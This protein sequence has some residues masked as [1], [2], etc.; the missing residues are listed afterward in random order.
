MVEL[1]LSHIIVF[2]IEY[3]DTESY[4]YAELFVVNRGQ[5]LVT[6]KWVKFNQWLGEVFN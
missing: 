1:L 5:D 3:H 4:N 2:T 6:Q